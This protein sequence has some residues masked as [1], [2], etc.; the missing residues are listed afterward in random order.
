M[1]WANF[2]F[3]CLYSD[4]MRF[5]ILCLILLL[6]SVVH[7]QKNAEI[8]HNIR[9]EFRAIN[10]IKNFE[11]LELENEEFLANAADGGAKLTGYYKNNSLRKMVVSVGL[12]NGMETLEF[13]FLKGKLIFV[14]E[15]FEGFVFNEKKSEF[16][17]T[18]TET[19]FEGRYYFDK[20][21][22]VDYI[23]TGH[24]RFDDDS[25]DP[26]KVWLEEAADYIKLLN[27]KKAQARRT[28]STD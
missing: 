2:L 27:K 19:T 6:S 24:N 15:K 13:Y 22:L 8:I 20:G 3:C 1:S 7:A 17:Y 28:N 25:L 12:S 9:K 11:T 26:G 14:Y 23:T 21:K 10:N 16:D 5:F 18:K 4:S